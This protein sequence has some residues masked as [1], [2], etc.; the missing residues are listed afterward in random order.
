MSVSPRLEKHFES[1]QHPALRQ[2]SWQRLI[3]IFRL[4][5]GTD[6]DQT[7]KFAAGDALSGLMDAMRSMKVGT[8]SRVWLP[9]DKAYGL[10]GKLPVV[11]PNQ[12]IEYEFE[13]VNAE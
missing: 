8:R 10:T 3:K 7:A 1:A 2:A 9:P 6:G 4:F 12:A 11:G 5:G 13:L